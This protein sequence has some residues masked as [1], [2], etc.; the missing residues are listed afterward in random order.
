[1]TNR[2]SIQ[3]QTPASIV[4]DANIQYPGA[5]DQFMTDVNQSQAIR[6]DA[7]K[8]PSIQVLVSNTSRYPDTTRAATRLLLNGE[9]VAQRRTL[10]YD[11][12]RPDAYSGNASYLL[13]EEDGESVALTFGA[14]QELW[15]YGAAVNVV[16]LSEL[17]GTSV[18]SDAPRRVTLQVRSLVNGRPGTALTPPITRRVER[19]HGNLKMEPVSLVDHYDSLSALRDSFVVVLEAGDSSNPLAVGMDRTADVEEPGSAYHR[20]DVDGDWTDVRDLHAEGRR[21]VGFRPMIRAQTAV[22]ENRSAASTLKIDTD[23]SREG[24]YVRLRA[25]FSLDSSG[26]Q[27]VGRLPS[28][29]IVEGQWVQKEGIDRPLGA[30][31][32]SEIVFA[33]PPESGADYQL[34]ARA[35]SKD[36]TVARRQFSWR[37]PDDVAVQADGPHPNPTI[38]DVKI[39]ITV[40]E[41]SQVEVTL[42]DVLGRKVRKKKPR[43]LEAGSH[44]LEF[45]LQ[46]L[47][48][49]VYFARIK[50]RRERDGYVDAITRKIIH[51]Q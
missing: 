18:S 12:G 39:P 9:R 33:F 6:T 15:L 48:N 23:H 45:H 8:H 43:S 49:G 37:I 46:G 14:S 3:E 21:L 44:H 40:L 38:R 25:P 26:T 50:T 35:T 29:R 7:Q 2:L 24:A 27:I 42:Y 47:S 13:L 1:M 10:Q 16:F 5:P 32:S 34:Y 36:R 22:P 19:S 20:S 28:G 17:S 51:M 4:Y 11:D 30:R 31:R 41:R